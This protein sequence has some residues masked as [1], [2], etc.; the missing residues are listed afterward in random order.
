MP[1]EERSYERVRKLLAKAEHPSTPPAEAE[2]LSEKAAEL[3]ARHTIDLA[4]LDAAGCHRGRPVLRSVHVDPPYATAKAL[5]L[6]AVAG[7]Y[8]VR[9]ALQEE[10]GSGGR[11]CTLV[12]FDADIAATDLLFTSLLLQSANAMLAAQ[13]TRTRRV[14][15]FRHAF[16]LGY[17][18]A[19]GQRLAAAGERAAA[20]PPTAGHSTA[21]VLA[22]RQA[23]VDAAFAGYFP[24][25][26]RLRTTLSDSAGLAAGTAAGASADLSAADR[27]LGPRPVRLPRR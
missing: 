5:L 9:T 13:P 21:L 16:L 26:R 19:I 10:P 18:A 23:A 11:C 7:C 27:R 25:L 15:A 6:A 20:D 22:D 8:R 17:A 14:R 1:P 2:L 24:R 4:V 12:G 3:I